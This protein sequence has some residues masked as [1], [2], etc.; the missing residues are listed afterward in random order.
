MVLA[1]K[2]SLEQSVLRPD[3]RGVW[4]W[5]R[6]NQSIRSSQHSCRWLT[7]DSTISRDRLGVG[8]D[9]MIHVRK[10]YSKGEYERSRGS[11]LHSS[12]KGCWYNGI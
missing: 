10:G 7:T 12:N 3:T 6:V 11:G 1:L 4:R 5:P 2:L 9:S 8:V